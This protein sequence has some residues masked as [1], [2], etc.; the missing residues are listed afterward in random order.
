MSDIK[1]DSDI[2]QK[3]GQEYLKLFADKMRDLA[4]EIIGEIEVKTLP[5]IETDAWTNY[6]ECLRSELEHDYKYSKFK[7]PWATNFRKTVFVEN[8]EELAQLISKDILDRIK[9]LEDCRQE[10]EVF[11]Y[12]PLGDTYQCLKKQNEALKEKLRVAVE[13]L[14]MISNNEH[15]EGNCVKYAEEALAKIKGGE[16]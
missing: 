9:H 2:I 3:E 5:H 7:E 1:Y 16:R 13:A 6:R 8:R 10:Y 4:S 15:W 12:T 11:R 14:R